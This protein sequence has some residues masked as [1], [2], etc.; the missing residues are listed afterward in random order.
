MGRSFSFCSRLPLSDWLLDEFFEVLFLVLEGSFG[1]GF[2]V[3][4]LLGGRCVPRF[5]LFT[6]VAQLRSRCSLA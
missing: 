4:L 6:G 5:V 1:I 3:S 2:G